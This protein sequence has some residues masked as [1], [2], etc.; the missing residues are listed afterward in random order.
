[1]EPGTRLMIPKRLTIETFYGCNA[2]CTMCPIDR[3]SRR[4]KGV[5]PVEIS[6]QVL[7]DL[8]PYNAEIDKVDFFGLGEPLL[9]PFICQRIRYAKAKG[10]RNI[11]FSTNADRLDEKKQ[12]EILD[13]G[14]ETILF[15]IDGV[16]KETHERIR[17]RVNFER[18][19][20]NCLAMI[21]R[22]NS[23][24]YRTRFVM[25]FIRQETNQHEWEPFKAFWSEK[26]SRSRNDLLIVYDVHSW[27]GQMATKAAI[28]KAGPPDPVIEAAPCH[29]LDY[30]IVL[31]DGTVPLCSEDFLEG[32]H[33]FGN[34]KD[35]RPMDIFGGPQFNATRKIHAEGRKASLPLCRECTVLYSEK[36][37]QIEE[38]GGL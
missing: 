27:G 25:R 17:R 35:T 33:G 10:F 21:E 8:A 1:M 5:M 7:D 19:V 37:R 31:A 18:V 24:G 26:L 12:Q 20:A 16:H 9:D 29:H 22:R 14:I 3:P 23:E 36:S 15:S 4:A 13:T 30:L 28:L 32:K 11:A 34:V 2:S 38:V 6:N